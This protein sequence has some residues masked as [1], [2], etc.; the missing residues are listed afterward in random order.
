[1]PRLFKSTYDIFSFWEFGG[2]FFKHKD[3]NSVKKPKKYLR[4][5]PI[6]IFLGNRIN[7][8]ELGNMQLCSYV[9]HS[10]KNYC[11]SDSYACFPLPT[12]LMKLSWLESSFSP[13][14]EWGGEGRVS[15]YVAI[16]V[17]LWVFLWSGPHF[18]WK[19]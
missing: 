14:N 17:V 10:R 9:V 12:V 16:W 15:S 11:F 8:Q 19:P 7:I 3:K 13:R 1:M 4:K 18:T 6:Q 2:K 5:Y